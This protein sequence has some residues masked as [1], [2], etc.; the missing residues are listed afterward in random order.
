MKRIVASL[1]DEIASLIAE[2]A[3]EETRS[4]SNMLAVLA[5]EAIDAR[6]EQEEAA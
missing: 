1:D 6:Q 3:E 5:R 4:L 2:L